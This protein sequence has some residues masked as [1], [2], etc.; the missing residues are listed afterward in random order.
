MLMFDIN[1]IANYRTILHFKTSSK[2]K[3]DLG[4]SLIDPRTKTV[5]ITDTFLAF[6]LSEQQQMVYK[7]GTIG[8]VGLYYNEKLAD[9]RIHIYFDTACYEK[10]L[11]SNNIEQWF[12]S[13]LLDIE[14]QIKEQP[15]TA[16]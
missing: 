11:D 12:A 15:H 14:N 6:Q 3:M 5:N 16:A 10:Q 1:V 13:A 4:R 7:I 9:H 8:K 2:F